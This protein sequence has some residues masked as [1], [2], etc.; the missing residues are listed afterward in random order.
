MILLPIVSTFAVLIAAQDTTSMVFPSA[1]NGSALELP[2][3]LE[4]ARPLIVPTNHFLSVPQRTFIDHRNDFPYVYDHP[5]F[6]YPVAHSIDHSVGPSSKQLVIVSFIG[7]LLLFAIIQ[8]TI[9]VVKRRDIP[10]DVLSARKKRDLYAAHN[11]YSVS[12]EQE[13]ILN[14]DA[15]V[16][17]IQRTVCFE[18]RKLSKAFG[19]VG[20]ILAKYLTRSI[21]KSLKSTSGWDR[22]V[23]DAGEAGIRNEDCDVLYRDCKYPASSNFGDVTGRASRLSKMHDNEK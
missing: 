15:R 18:N 23:E 16:R 4:P 12:S 21:G 7:L 10:T 19:V 3:I 2:S 17:C 1:R 22:L 11:F 13:A 5:H 14:D 9:A 6:G 8:N 20:K